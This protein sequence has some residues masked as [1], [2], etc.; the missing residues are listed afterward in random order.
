MQNKGDE[1]ETMVRQARQSVLWRPMRP[2]YQV[3]GTSLDG[4]FRALLTK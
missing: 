3:A 1:N 4:Y 2:W